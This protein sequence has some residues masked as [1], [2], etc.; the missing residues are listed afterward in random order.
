MYRNANTLF[1]IYPHL[2]HGGGASDNHDDGR[3]N[4]NNRGNNSRNKLVSVGL[5]PPLKRSERAQEKWYRYSKGDTI[6]PELF[7]ITT[8]VGVAQLTLDVSTVV[9]IATSIAM[10]LAGTSAMKKMSKERREKPFSHPPSP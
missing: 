6:S 9:S 4:G 7:Q 2:H 5:H 10:I 3:P 8:E 1:R